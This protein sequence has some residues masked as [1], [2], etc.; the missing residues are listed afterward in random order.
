MVGG[1]DDDDDD[2]DGGEEAFVLHVIHLFEPCALIRLLAR[3]V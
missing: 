3:Y 2:D 1:G